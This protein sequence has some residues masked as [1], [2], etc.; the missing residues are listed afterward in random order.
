MQKTVYRMRTQRS[1]EGRLALD[2]LRE[3]QAQGRAGTTQALHKARV[4]MISS[5][6]FLAAVSKFALILRLAS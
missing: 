3:S 2:L 5:P 6:G 1:I 4:G